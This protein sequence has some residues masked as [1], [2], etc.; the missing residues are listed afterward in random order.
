MGT[1]Y[2]LCDLYLHCLHSS[3]SCAGKEMQGKNTDWCQTTNISPLRKSLSSIAKC[4]LKKSLSMRL[5]FKKKNTME[6]W[7]CVKWFHHSHQKLNYSLAF[8]KPLLCRLFTVIGN[9]QSQIICMS[10]V[11]WCF[12]YAMPS[13]NG[14]MNKEA[15][16]PWNYKTLVVCVNLQC[17]F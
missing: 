5:F 9:R 17:Q 8:V 6:K 3:V 14:T 1:K 13:L 2:M 12:N 11:I 16:I 15:I 10:A 4:L 7:Q